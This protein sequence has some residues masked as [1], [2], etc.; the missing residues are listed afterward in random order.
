M[1]PP[2]EQKIITFAHSLILRSWGLKGGL[3]TRL[4]C[5]LHELRMQS[6]LNLV[7]IAFLVK[8]NI[9]SVPWGCPFLDIDFT[10]GWAMKAIVHYIGTV[11]FI[12]HCMPAC[13]LC[14][15][16]FSMIYTVAL[17]VLH[18][19]SDWLQLLYM[20][21][22]SKL[23]VLTEENWVWRTLTHYHYGSKVHTH[24]FCMFITTYW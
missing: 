4:F 3:G 6:V 12:I 24:T 16:W 15:Q 7:Q 14:K 13:D 5:S 18:C 11:L 17:L 23:H 10:Q 20:M 21:Y 22:Y 19:L 1:D 9:V 8:E 2:F